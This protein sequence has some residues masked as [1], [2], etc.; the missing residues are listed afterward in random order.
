M[1]EQPVVEAQPGESASLGFT[2][3]RGFLGA[4]EDGS[5]LGPA[6]T[7]LGPA[8]FPPSGVPEC[9]P[10]ARTMAAGSTRS[11]PRVLRSTLDASLSPSTFQRRRF[12]V[13]LLVTPAGRLA[14]PTDGRLHVV[15]GLRRLVGPRRL[16]DRCGGQ[17]LA[18]AV[19][20][21]EWWRRRESNPRP[22][23]RLRGNLHACP[24]LNFSLPVSKDGG[25]RRKPAP[26]SLAGTCRRHARRPAR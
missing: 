13:L 20:D 15:V 21:L 1:A 6:G 10:L 26:K 11:R 25:N 14:S 22:K 9:C 5:L 4:D 24:P 18:V 17:R 12:A 23:V 16:R 7:S 8:G 19:G 3:D 2:I